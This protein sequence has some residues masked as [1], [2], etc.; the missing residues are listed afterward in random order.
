LAVVQIGDGRTPIEPLKP[1]RP[2]ARLQMLGTTTGHIDPES[3]RRWDAATGA[4]V[5]AV[6]ADA[7]QLYVNIKPLLDEA[8]IELGHSGEDF[9]AA[10][11]RATTMLVETP[12]PASE[13]MLL[14][15]PGYFDYDDPALR[16]LRPVQK[17]F[18]LVGPENR[19]HLVTWLKSF[20]S[21]LDL[22]IQ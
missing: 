2:S 3:Y 18:L 21:A 15:R 6:P 1:L 13:P 9:D 5:T 8:Y 16:A 10:I 20:A 7:A 11:V 12:E 17:Q 4:L 19:R 14:K 22:K